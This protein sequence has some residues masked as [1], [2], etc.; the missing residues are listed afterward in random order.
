MHSSIP[1]LLDSPEECYP[2][3]RSTLDFP[4]AGELALAVSGRSHEPMLTRKRVLLA[5]GSVLVLAVLAPRWKTYESSCEWVLHRQTDGKWKI[6]KEHI[7][8]RPF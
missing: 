2:C 5:M 6:A 4:C 1:E 3:A 7:Q 8:S